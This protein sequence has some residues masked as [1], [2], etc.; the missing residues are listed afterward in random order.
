MITKY[1]IIIIVI[2]NCF[3]F[4]CFC[5]G[6]QR[7]EQSRCVGYIYTRSQKIENQIVNE[8]IVTIYNLYYKKF[9]NNLNDFSW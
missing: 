4:D 2:L 7:G 3:F 5:F 8:K 9:L 6:T 1:E